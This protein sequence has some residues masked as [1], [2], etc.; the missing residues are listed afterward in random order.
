MNKA[1]KCIIICILLQIVCLAPNAFAHTDVTPMEAK[2]LIDNNNKLLVIDVREET[3]YCS[4]TGH[5]PGAHNYP[6]ISGVLEQKYQELPLEGEL[7]IVCQSGH[8][9]NTAAEFLDANGYQ[10]VYDMEG[11]M[12]AWEW[13]TVGCIDTDGDGV[14]DDL[15]NCPEVSNPDQQDTDKNGIGDACENNNTFCPAEILYGENSEEAM[16]LRDFRDTVLNKTSDGQKIIRLYYAVSP[17]L[18]TMIEKDKELKDEIKTVVDELL[19]RLREKM[20]QN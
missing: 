9:S 8:R 4:D 12:S 19:P 3:E 18:V 16:L 13:E 17:M 1:C 15:D 14:N 20:H 2:A 6:L 11:G 10:H 7:L 5:I